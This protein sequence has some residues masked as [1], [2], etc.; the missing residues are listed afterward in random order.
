[1]NKVVARLVL[2]TLLVSFAA[3]CSRMESQPPTVTFNREFKALGSSPALSVAV[4]D[5]GTGLRHVAIHL[6]QR[7]KPTTWES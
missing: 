2:V 7:P 4:E 6:K 5:S 3:G 1:M